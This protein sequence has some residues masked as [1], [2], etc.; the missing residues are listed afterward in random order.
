MLSTALTYD[1]IY[2]SFGKEADNTKPKDTKTKN[3]HISVSKTETKK[4]DKV[5][6]TED[7]RALQQAND[8]SQSLC[9]TSGEN[10]LPID[11]NGITRCPDGIF[12][13]PRGICEKPIDNTGKPP[14]P[15]GQHSSP[16]GICESDIQCTYSPQGCPTA[17]D[18]TNTPVPPGCL[19]RPQIKNISITDRVI[20]Y[21]ISNPI[22]LQQITQQPTNSIT[23]LDT[24]QFCTLSKTKFVYI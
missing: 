1:Q 13:S 21:Y 14:C 19:S 5:K 22:I 4:K 11:T 18:C 17:F 20:K 16:S 10:C 6:P 8:P 7:N 15:I 2:P 24:I 9:Y 3:K 12:R 23:Q